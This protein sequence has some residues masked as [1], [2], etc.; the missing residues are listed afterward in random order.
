MLLRNSDEHPSLGSHLDNY[1]HTEQ[2]ALPINTQQAEPHRRCMKSPRLT[3]QT[4]QMT[5]QETSSLVSATS[6]QKMFSPL[7]R[8]MNMTYSGTTSFPSPSSSRRDKN[9][10]AVDSSPILTSAQEMTPAT[11]PAIYQ[12]P[13]LC[14]FS[15]ILYLLSACCS[16]ARELSLLMSLYG[17][18]ST[19]TTMTRSP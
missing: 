13:S 10:M 18:S 6:P 14:G 5:F 16:R 9:Y 2:A 15:V 17:C 8:T 12:L 11:H 7:V 19:Q 1:R 4:V 3:M